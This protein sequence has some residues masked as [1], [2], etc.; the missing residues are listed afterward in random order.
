VCTAQAALFDRGGGLIYD[1]VFHI[2]WLADANYF[3]TRYDWNGAN[4]AVLNLS[5]NDKVRGVTYDD[6]RLPNATGGA[7]S[8]TA[9]ALGY[10]S[11]P[12]NCTES[13]VLYGELL[14][15]AIQQG[16]LNNLLSNHNSSYGLFKNIQA[17]RYWQ[18]EDKQQTNDA[19]YVDM[20]N[21][22]YG[23]TNKT[24]STMFVWAVRDG[25]VAS[26]AAPIPEPQTYAMML[27]GLGL[28]GLIARR[29]K[30]N[31][32]QSCNDST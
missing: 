12:S 22:S 29:R 32:L 19:S 21:G 11:Y 14:G 26:V 24:G 2:T 20:T 17:S 9:V 13:N 23:T 25:D 18:S 15:P 6:W 10:C 7:W 4:A 1:D 3:E 30:L 27:A 5:F 16:G 28:I 31:A 8:Y